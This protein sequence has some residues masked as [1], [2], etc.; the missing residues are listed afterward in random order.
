MAATGGELSAETSLTGRVAIVTG[1]SRGVGTA[2]AQ[3][4]VDRGARVAVVARNRD[5][6]T[7]VARRLRDSGGA[8]LPVCCDLSDPASAAKVVAVTADRLGPVDVIVNNAGHVG[9]LGPL[10]SINVPDW[11][12]TVRLNLVSAMAII[13]TALPGMLA[14][15]FGRIVN[16]STGAAAGTGM[17][18]ASAYSA[19]KAG[20][21]MLTR[22]LAAELTGT[23]VAVAAVRPGR[24]DTDMQRFL[25]AQRADEVGE[26]VV[27]R[28]HAFLHDGQLLDP[29]V[30]AELIVRVLERG[31]SGEVISVY[32]ERGRSLLAGIRYVGDGTPG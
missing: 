21:E 32:D 11:A 6:L 22:N 10:T 30:P 4:L 29:A 8:V 2:V 23:G 18:G 19:S 1:A 9:P 5:G 14:R 20:L 13:A 28:A 26:A 15:D 17:L 3:L 27:T 12:S 16:V 24:V 31:L 7:A 25:R